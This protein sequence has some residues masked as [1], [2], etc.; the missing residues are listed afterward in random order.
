MRRLL[1]LLS[2]ILMAGSLSTRADELDVMQSRKRPLM[3]PVNQPPYAK[4]DPT[5]VTLSG[6]G[7]LPSLP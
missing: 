5:T 7:R 3:G 4:Y 1:L 6:A 2:T